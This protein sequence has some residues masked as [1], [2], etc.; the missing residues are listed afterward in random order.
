[1]PVASRVVRPGGGFATIL[2]DIFRKAGLR[3][4]RPLSVRDLGLDLV[5]E[6]KDKKYVVQL[7][8][9]SEGRRDRL[10]PLLSQA[11]LQARE[12]AQNFPEP[13]VPI[14]VVA[15][16]R[17]PASVAEQIQQFAQRYAPE[18]GVGVIDAEGFRSFAVAGLERLDARPPGR[19]ARNIA[20]A[21]HLPDLFSDLNQWM[22][23]IL[24]GL[25]ARKKYRRRQKAY[26]VNSATTFAG[27]R[28]SL[29]NGHSLPRPS[30]RHAATVSSRYLCS[31]TAKIAVRPDENVSARR[32][33]PGTGDVR[34]FTSAGRRWRL[35]R[36][37]RLLPMRRRWQPYRR[38]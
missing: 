33:T 4:R 26:L 25:A 28:R 22:L 32:S 38:W 5:F 14:A 9:A 36:W 35:E 19:V 31:L 12:I 16:K 30:G 11:I 8:V 29:P 17:M 23:K 6:A 27:Q 13:A 18:V 20:S 1:M 24:L 3:L 34:E 15:A 37:P 21:R 7:K 10:I 2:T